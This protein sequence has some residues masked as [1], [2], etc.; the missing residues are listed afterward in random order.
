M[1]NY[2][3]IDPNNRDIQSINQINLN[4]REKFQDA[5]SNMR[6]MIWNQ[7]LMGVASNPQMTKK[8]KFVIIQ[9]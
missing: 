3:Q 2:N 7:F 6:L 1:N 9:I 5:V 8:K 4:K